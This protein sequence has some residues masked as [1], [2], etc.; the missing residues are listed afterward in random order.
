MKSH[1]KTAGISAIKWS[2]FLS[3]IFIIIPIIMALLAGGRDD[4]GGFAGKRMVLGIGAFP[5]VFIGLWVWGIISKKEPMT[6][7]GFRKEKDNNMSGNKKTDKLKNSIIENEFYKIAWDEIEN[8]KTKQALWSKSFA[9]SDGDENKTKAKYINLRVEEL[10]I[11]K[12]KIIPNHEKSKITKND[13]EVSNSRNTDEPIINKK[14]SPTLNKT[15]PPS[16]F[17]GGYG[18]KITFWLFAVIPFV[19]FFGLIVNFPEIGKKAVQ[20]IAIVWALH[21]TILLRSL[22]LAMR[23]YKGDNIWKLFTLA[24]IIL[25][26]LWL[27]ISIIPSSIEGYNRLYN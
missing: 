22:W 18:L 11:E 26:L 12:T 24:Y 10:K 15:S 17:N 13:T 7:I 19:V 5:I 1:I 9:D 2:F 21:E 20:A 16:I 14:K 6:N 27:V 8:N 23:R 25:F 3:V 4:L